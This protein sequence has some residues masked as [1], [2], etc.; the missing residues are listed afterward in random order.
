MLVVPGGGFSS[1][2]LY[3]MRFS[4]FIYKVGNRMEKRELLNELLTYMEAS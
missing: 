2:E 4:R 1:S 3:Y